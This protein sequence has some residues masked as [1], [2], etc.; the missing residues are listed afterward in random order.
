M[1]L[2]WK[3]ILCYS[4]P[5]KSYDSFFFYR[6]KI[7]VIQKDFTYNITR[8]KKKLLSFSIFIF[9]IFFDNLII[10]R[11]N[12][13]KHCNSRNYSLVNIHCRRYTRI[14]YYTRCHATITIKNMVL[15]KWSHNATNTIFRRN[16]I[17]WQNF[18][19]KYRRHHKNSRRYVTMTSQKIFFR[20]EFPNTINITIS[21]F[22]KNHVWLPLCDHGVW[23]P[24]RVLD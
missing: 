16:I 15:R 14:P 4:S 12:V 24:L 19:E 20:K 18:V 13:Q 22:V 3:L 23:K 17:R 5:K 6:R 10:W 2:H 21:K 11:R 9:F 7:N 1:N 8:W